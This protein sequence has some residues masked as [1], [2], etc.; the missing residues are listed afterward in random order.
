MLENTIVRQY[1]VIKLK[2]KGEKKNSTSFFLVL[3]VSFFVLILGIF[4]VRFNSGGSQIIKFRKLTGPVLNPLMGWTPWAYTEKSSQPHTL[5]YADLTWR[6]FEP[7]EGIFDFAAFEEKQQ[8]ARWRSEGKRIVFRFVADAPGEEAHMDIPDWLF[9]KIGGDGDF[10][11]NEYGKGFSPNY[12]NPLLI[13]YHHLAI[14]AL[15][16]RYGKDGFFA[17]VELGSLGH[18]GEWHENSELRQLPPENIRDLYVYDYAYAFPDTHLLMRRPFT[19]AEKLGLGLYNDMTGDIQSTN[20]WL[21]WIENGGDY[22]P[23]EKNTLVPMPD[24]WKKAPVGGEQSPDISNEK[25][26][27]VDLE[28]T[29][30]LLKESHTTFIGPGGGYD[31][32]FNGALQSGIDQVLS[33]IGYRLYIDRAEMP[34]YV[35]FGD[36]AQIKLYFANDGIAPFYYD[37]PFRLY[38]FDESGKVL[39]EYLLPLDVREILPD[40]ICPVNFALP[41]GDLKNGRYGIG[42]ALIDPLT[43]QPSIKLANENTRSDLIM[44]IGSFEVKRLFILPNN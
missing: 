32:E 1:S 25:A 38:L 42:V 43:G 13:Q 41:V 31:V 22:L 40:T 37:W 27:G 20:T 26:Y 8:L 6:D 24:G 16:D 36:K 3:S 23:D 9:K 11:D 17:F 12:A 35:K 33:T 5:V 39:A 18:W 15:G 14:K 28:I 30:Q 19:V 44:N 21:D 29:L 10:Y 34:L 4:V 7:Q 2:G